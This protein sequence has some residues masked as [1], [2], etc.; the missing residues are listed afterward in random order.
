MKAEGNSYLEKAPFRIFGHRGLPRRIRENTALSIAA[1]LSAGADGCEMDL[2]ELADRSVVLFHDHERD[3]R[4]VESFSRPELAAIEG[5]LTELSEVLPLA[6]RG[7]L[8]LE[9]KRRGWEAGLLKALTGWP[10]CIVSSFDHTLIRALRELEAPFELGAILSGRLT[11]TASYL[12]RIGATWFFPELSHVD[13][14]LVGECAAAGIR[15]VPWTADRPDQWTLLRDYGCYG[16]ITNV[17]DAAV[18]WRG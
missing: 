12:Q 9:I 14:L 10:P 4:P 2:R 17:A 6:T 5:D 18:K 11:E 7:L 15:V 1:A 13:Y 16:V 8:I 3:N